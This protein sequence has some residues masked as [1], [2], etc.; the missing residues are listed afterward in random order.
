[1]F[2][3]LFKNAAAAAPLALS[4]LLVGATVTTA[5]GQVAAPRVS[6]TTRG[7]VKAPLDLNT[8]TAEEM[9]ATLPGVGEATARKIING[10]P[11]RSVDDLARAGVPAREINAI[12]RHVTVIPTPAAGTRPRTRPGTAAPA[13]EP[14]A[15]VNLNT[16]SAQELQTLP[17]I[18]PAHARAIVAA[19]PIRSLNDLERIKG[20]GGN[21]VEA[22]RDRID[23]TP[24]APATTRPEPTPR[25]A[26]ARPAPAIS[27]GDA[28]P[29]TR[30]AVRPGGSPRLAPGRVV[31]INTATREELDALPGIGPVKAQAIVDA[32]PFRTKEDVMKVKGIKQGEFSKIRAL[33]SVE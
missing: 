22:I 17:G 1:M 33:I 7:T 11:Y 21:R 26:M 2:V 6:P 18:G 5:P 3:P 27:P 14:T 9:T 15:R 13:L 8:A 32:R 4:V 31:N 29:A 10:R 28:A 16:A 30:P 24:P 25:K 19:R 20:L 12:R 23:L